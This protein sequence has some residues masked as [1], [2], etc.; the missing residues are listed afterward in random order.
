MQR[1]DTRTMVKDPTSQQFNIDSLLE[2]IDHNG[3]RPLTEQEADQIFAEAEQELQPLL[4][5]MRR[6]DF[7]EIAEMVLCFCVILGAYAGILYQCLTF[8]HTL[9][10]LYAKT[11]PATISATLD[12]PTRTLA[13]VTITRSA[14]GATS[15]RG[16][17][18]ARAATGTVT[19]YNGLSVGQ[20]V[21]AG[22][23]LT[24]NDGMQIET[25]QDAV[26]PAADPTATPPTDG[27]ATVSAQAV[28]TG[29][30]GNIS[31]YDVAVV[32]SSSLT[33]KNLA[34]FTKGQDARTFK[35]VAPR[36]LTALTSMVNDSVT[37]ALTTAF[38]L[39]PGE[40]ALSTTCTTKATSTH[41]PG[42]EAQSVTL[43]ITRICPAVA[44][45]SQELHRQATAAFTRTRPG[46]TYHIVGNVQITV[47]SVSPLTVRLRGT[48][49]Y[50]FSQDYQDLL[51]QE[52]QGE[53]P[54]KAKASL[55]KTG[56]ISYAS[57][58]NTL[59]S[60]GFINFVVLVD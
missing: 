46:A 8:P 37:Q 39:Q 38:P 15:G 59:P 2:S 31:A 5:K 53:S 20:T 41:Q 6:D 34:A 44:Y 48:W 9:V 56:V 36:D 18:K 26:I 57:V 14:T 47:Q 22:T 19:F 45:R 10:I 1:I 25:T 11:T 32:F 29:M 43:T 17:Q 49:A 23:V 51:A 27:F 16:Y 12:I 33:V 13:P 52:I 7:F 3:N 28:Q 54:E 55:L 35:A 50:T 30:K 42:E 21:R 60:A 24:G 4:R 58:P 40:A